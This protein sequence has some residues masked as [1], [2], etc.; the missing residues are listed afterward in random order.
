[1]IFAGTGVGDT[2]VAKPFAS[3]AVLTA[4]DVLHVGLVKGFVMLG[5]HEYVVEFGGQLTE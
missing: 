2:Q 4:S 5:L 3:M 1:M